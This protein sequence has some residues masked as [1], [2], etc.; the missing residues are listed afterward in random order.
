MSRYSSAMRESVE[1]MLRDFSPEDLTLFA[2]VLD[3]QPGES[4]DLL[5]AEIRRRA[6]LVPWYRRL[7]LRLRPGPPSAKVI[8]LYPQLTTTN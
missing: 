7:W 2:Q 6:R 8:P 5:Q 4:R 3:Q 1:R